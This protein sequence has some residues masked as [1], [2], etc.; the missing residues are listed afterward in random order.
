MRERTLSV[1]S[2]GKTF[3]FT[4]WKVGWACGPAALVAA[5]RSAKQFLTYA[6]RRPVPVRGGRGPGA[7]DRYFSGDR[8]CR[9][10]E[11]R[12]LFC[13]GLEDRAWRCT[14]RPSTYFVTTDIAPLG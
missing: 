10:A 12:D 13:A 3:S 2:A 1:S 14:A 6:E 8:P 7:G 5:V 9:C 11:P 4:G